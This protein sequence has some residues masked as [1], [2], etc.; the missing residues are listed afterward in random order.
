MPTPESVLGYQPGADYKLTRYTESLAYFQK[1]AGASDKIRLERVGKT[2]EGQDWYIAIISSAENLKNVDRYREIAR[3][4]AL[5]QDLNDD[6]ARKLAREGKVIVHLDGGLHSTECAGQ[7]HTIQLA[8]DL[9]SNTAD[10][11]IK[12]ILDNVITV[13]WFSL[14]PDGQNMVADWYRRNLGTPY[15]VSSMPWLYQKYVGHDNNRDGYMNNMIESQVVTRVTV[16][17]WHPMVYF[18]HHQTAPFPARIWIPPFAEPISSN[19]HPLIWRWTNV[20][21]TAMASYLDQRDMPGSIH[22]VNFD[23]WYPG[24]IDGVNNYRNTISFLT[25]TA[26]YRYAT[27]RFYTVSDFPKG[28][29]GAAAGGLLLESVEG[30]LVAA[31]RRRALYDRRVDERARYGREISRGNHLQPLPGRA[32]CDPEVHLGAALRLHHST[33]PARSANR[34]AAGG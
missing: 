30:R 13:L 9:V 28:I 8:Y 22:R 6:A 17:Q 7:E 11:Q 19:V 26:L 18:N 12:F 2:S 10:P 15:E 20:F 23:D 27:P 3:R 16:E 24:F 34:R 31:G 1:L 5:V 14:N 33:A 4:I 29:S 21:G 32:R 25:E